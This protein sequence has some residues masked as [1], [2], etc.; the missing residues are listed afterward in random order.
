ME[1]ENRIKLDYSLE[2]P[3]ERNQLVKKIVEQT[4]SEELTNSYLERLA[5]YIVFAMD[6][7]EKQQSKILTGNRMVT[8]NKRQMSFE[9]L[10]S[11]FQNGEDGIYSM[12]TNDKNI[13]FMPKISITEDNIRNI[14]GMRELRQQIEKVEAR[15]KAARGRRKFLLMRQLI[16][17]RKEQYVLKAAYEPK[18]K[19]TN[20]TKSFASLSIEE[21]VKILPGGDLQVNANLSLMI[22]SHVQ[23]LLCNYSKIKEECWDKQ[24]S[25]MYYLMLDLEKTVDAALEEKYPYLYQLVILKIDGISN[26]DIQRQLQEKFEVK[27]SLEYISSLWRNKIP[28]LVAEQAQKDWLVWHYTQEEKGVW[29][30]CSCCGQIKLGHKFFF[31]KNN[32]SKDGFYSICKDCRSAKNKSKKG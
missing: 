21:H 26:E 25:D 13:I 27:H 17:M 5:D 22:P 14:P 6:K 1:T 7:G 2:T 19:Y 28:K 30:R 12:I 3:Q 11:K 4:P 31:S 8:V 9:G 10:V 16:E 29:K 24:N 23:A 18:T 32:T 15:A 20:I